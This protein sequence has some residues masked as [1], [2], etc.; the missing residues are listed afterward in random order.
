MMYLWIAGCSKIKASPMVGD[1]A[2][3]T[4]CLAVCRVLVDGGSLDRMRRPAA[5]EMGYRKSL[6]EEM[7]RG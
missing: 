7:K 2:G 5:R 1:W 4:G 6:S 3:G